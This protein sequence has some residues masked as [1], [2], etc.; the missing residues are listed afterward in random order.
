MSGGSNFSH[1]VFF[2]LL[3]LFFPT[4]I[5]V[6]VHK[7]QTTLNYLIV[8]TT[9]LNW[10]TTMKLLVIYLWT[11]KDRNQRKSSWRIININIE[12]VYPRDFPKNK[13]FSSRF[14]R[15]CVT[16]NLCIVVDI[17][18]LHT[19]GLYIRLREKERKAKERT[20]KTFSVWIREATFVFIHFHRLIFMTIFMHFMC[21]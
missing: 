2:P 5:T 18:C 19:T 21:N 16:R 6:H 13:K 4:M 9:S 12:R 14:A 11:F 17:M 7:L 3:S 20:K 10:R 8:M 1:V 15:K